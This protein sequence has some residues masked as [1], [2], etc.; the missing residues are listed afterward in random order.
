[1]SEP[2]WWVTGHWSLVTGHWSLVTWSLV[3]GQRSAV[4]APRRY[5]GAPGAVSTGT[6]LVP[7][8]PSV[9]AF[10]FVML[11]RGLQASDHFRCGF[12]QCLRLRVF[13]LF[14]VFAKMLDELAKFPPHIRRMCS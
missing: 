7:L 11:K 4:A 6:R 14:Y 8:F 2:P 9:F 12:E 1:M 10:R 5:L 13:H 3:T